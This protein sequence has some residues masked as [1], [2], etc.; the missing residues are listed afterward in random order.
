MRLCVEFLSDTG[1]HKRFS[2]TGWGSIEMVA[3]ESAIASGLL[4]P[5]TR[6]QDFSAPGHKLTG[7]CYYFNI[8]NGQSKDDGLEKAINWLNSRVK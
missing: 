8:S 5:V 6:T 3:L 2:I 1:D 7:R 4:P